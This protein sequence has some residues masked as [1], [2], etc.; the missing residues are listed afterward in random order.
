MKT[1]GRKMYPRNNSL[2]KEQQDTIENLIEQFSQ[3]DSFEGLKSLN[4][5]FLNIMMKKERDAFLR[6]SN[7]NKGNGFYPRSIA[8]GLGKIDL[9][10]PRDRLNEF[11]PFLLP[12]Q[13]QRGDQSYDDLLASLIIHA[14]SPNKIRSV[15]KSLN[16]SYSDNDINEIRDEIFQRSN[17]FKT[18]ELDANALCIYID[19][20][21]TQIK[22]PDTHKVT[23]AAIYSV[24][25]INLD[26]KK[27]I[28]GY[29]E[30]FGSETKEHWLTILNDLIKRGLKKILLIISDDFPGLSQA[31]QALFAK[32]DH[33]LCFIHMQRNVHKNMG[34]ADSRDFN[35]S[36]KTIRTYKDKEKAIEAFSTLCE[37]YHK[38]YP[39]FIDHLLKN[40][41]RYFAFLGY[42]IDLQKHIYTT[43][44]VESFNSRL[45]VMRINIGG[46]FQTT[47]TLSI[48]MQVLIDK[49][50]KDKWHHP[51][52]TVKGCQYEIYGSLKF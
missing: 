10:I 25:G 30:H 22:D 28:Y 32:T 5:A 24:I 14:Y 42:P 16:L 36:L 15:L 12:E 27:E 40:K 17:E 18:R 4:E 38:K 46:Y 45:E 1:K 29:Y 2:N 37:N 20:Y 47:K 11:R 44:P 35:N 34:K 49:L 50:T 43:N 51:I 33:Q 39:A 52:P 8:T 41:E 9:T 21:H 23:K 3:Q 19:A 26:G 13:W 6:T 31:I 48:A 7:N